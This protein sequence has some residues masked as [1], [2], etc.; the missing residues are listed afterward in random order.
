[1]TKYVIITPARDEEAHIET[2]IL[3]V[4]HQTVRPVQWIIVNDGSRDDTGVIINGYV[5]MHQWITPLH[6]SDRG[7]RQAGGGVINAF[8]DGYDLIESLDWEFIVKLDADL[9]FAPDYFERCFAE[10]AKDSHLGIAGGGIYHQAN[11]GV[12]LEES[13]LF[14]VRGATKIYKRECWDK[15]GGLLRAP[16]WDT[17]DEVKA[18]MLGWSTRTFPNLQVSH[19]RFTGAA[20]GAWKDSVKNGRANYITGYH[21]VFMLFKCMRKM[22]TRPMSGLGLLWGFFG[23]YCERAPQVEDRTLIKYTRTQQMRRLLLLD[24]IWK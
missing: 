21:P 4:V 12:T 13:P 19:H 22:A 17:V 18:N 14:H 24:S 11:G 5:Q 8:Y 23:G 16:G 1:M 15:L 3:S 20:D 10:F 7:F 9:S 6:R 2:T